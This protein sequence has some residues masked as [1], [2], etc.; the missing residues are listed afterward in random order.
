ML[1]QPQDTDGAVDI[2]VL[3]RRVATSKGWW[4]LHLQVQYGDP[5]DHSGHPLS[6]GS[7][8]QDWQRIQSL[9]PCLWCRGCAE[10]YTTRSLREAI[11]GQTESSLQTPLSSMYMEQFA[12]REGNA[13]AGNTNGSTGGFTHVEGDGSMM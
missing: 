6:H 3:A 1:R 10:P 5:R 12:S 7:Q 4:E 2:P 11:L 13:L 9:A 8:H